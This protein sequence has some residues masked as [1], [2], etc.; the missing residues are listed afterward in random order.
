MTITRGMGKGGRPRKVPAESAAI[1][2]VIPEAMLRGYQ[3][4]RDD[5][6][7]G[8][9]GAGSV[10]TQDVMRDVLERALREYQAGKRR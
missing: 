5:V 2:L 6:R 1:Y 4:W 10:T 3:G 7:A 9:V 8:T